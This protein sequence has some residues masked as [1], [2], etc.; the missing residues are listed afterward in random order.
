[1]RAGKTSHR[2]LVAT[3]VLFTTLAAQTAWSQ[4][5]PTRPVKMLHGFSAGTNVDT[6]T[7]LV[8][9]D[10][11][12][13]L[14]QP[15]VVEAQA[16][17]GSTLAAGTVARARPDGYTLLMTTGSHSVAGALYDKL[18]YDTEKSFSSISTVTFFA[19]AVTAS[20][21]GRY[22][23]LNDLIAYARA[24]PGKV[25]YGSSGSGSTNHLAGEV[26]ASITNTRM[27]HV[28]YKGFAPA[29]TA[30]L[31]GEIDFVVGSASSVLGNVKAG[32]MRV[33][34]M[35]APRRWSGMSDV[36]TSFEQGLKDYDM[37]SWAGIMAPAELPRAIVD[38]LH[39]DTQ[40]V[41]QVPSVRATLEELGGEPRGST[42]AEMSALISSELKRWTQVVSDAKIPK[43]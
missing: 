17:A 8:A 6:I 16:G 12:K 41:L 28:P 26:L 2:A 27:Q 1:M 11:S 33:L 25:N 9:G 22:Q 4:A 19:F 38:R 14:G 39:A 29:L 10:L 37:S 7:R 32:K 21:A 15:V 3:T 13:V 42:P 18:P 31:S 30:L 43:L 35:A 34:A 24:N 5:W 23:N 36:P 40:K 20:A